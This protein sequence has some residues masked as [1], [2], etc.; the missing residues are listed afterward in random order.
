GLSAGPGFFRAFF[1]HGTELAK[2]SVTVVAAGATVAVA[3]AWMAGVPAPL[4]A[5]V[6][7]GA[8]TSTP[9]LATALADLQND[10]MVSIGYG[11]AYPFG[12]V[13]VVLF[14]QLLPRLL[15]HDLEAEGHKHA[16]SGPDKNRIQRMLIEVCNPSI[17]GRKIQDVHFVAASRCQISRVLRGER[18]VPITSETV[19]EDG[20][21]LLAVGHDDRLQDLADFLGRRSD[22]PYYLDT[23]SELMQVVATAPAVVGKSLR[24]LN[25][26]NKF[27]VT[28]SRIIRHDVGFVPDAETVVQRADVLYAVGEP[29][30]IKQL[31]TFAGHRTRVLDE[32]DLIS[33]SA[34][35]IAGVLLGMTP[36]AFPGTQ[37]FTLGLAGGPL[38]VALVLGHFGGV[39]RIRGHMPRAARLLMTEAGLVFFLAAAG[40]KA[41]E[42]FLPVLRSQ[43]VP[44][45]VMGALISTLPMLLG[46]GFARRVLRLGLLE[47]YGGICGGMTSTPGLGALTSR[48]DSEVPTVS[49]AT[50]YPV[51]LI[52]V[53]V[54]AQMIIAVLT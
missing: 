48:T 20:Q 27:G 13:A 43:G 50:A 28:I 22:R 40:A 36:I 34:G 35:I 39:G 9:G 42:G 25:L 47:T 2:I 32:T 10:P 4:A 18:L 52:L 5:G 6:F 14:V 12:V 30:A 37:G 11:I 44:L 7:A 29:Q 16:A 24:E 21:H 46:Y 1:R 45:V 31:A 26:I 53:T 33:L 17:M 19:F 41:G 15:G 23:A 3:F 8:L 54:F 51:A 38:L 49:Y